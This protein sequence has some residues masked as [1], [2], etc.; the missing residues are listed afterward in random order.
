MTGLSSETFSFNFLR[1]EEKMAD[2]NFSNGLPWFGSFGLSTNLLANNFETY[3]CLTSLILKMYIFRLL[4]SF[5]NPILK[6]K[7]NLDI[8][9]A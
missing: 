7:L 9:F 5:I 2:K 8:S 4:V 3:F 1:I 6:K